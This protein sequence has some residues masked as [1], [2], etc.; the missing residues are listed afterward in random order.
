ML[1]VADNR[2]LAGESLRVVADDLVMLALSQPRSLDGCNALPSVI[3]RF[4][5]SPCPGRDPPDGLTPADSAFLAALYSAD[6]EAKKGTEQF[7]LAGRMAENLI[8]AN[9]ASGAGASPANVH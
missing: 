8:K 2:A 6:L 1:I 5:R 9:V 4:A 3:D 7:D